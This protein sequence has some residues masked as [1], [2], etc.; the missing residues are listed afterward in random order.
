MIENFKVGN[1]VIV[2]GKV[3]YVGGNYIQVKVGDDK[4][5]VLKTSASIVK[6]I[7][8][9]FDFTYNEKKFNYDIRATHMISAIVGNQLDDYGQP[10]GHT[11]LYSMLSENLIPKNSIEDELEMEE[12][13]GKESIQ[14]IN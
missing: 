14:D 5:L 8:G 10:V 7:K 11:R 3:V 9:K 4:L 1:D 6:P 13:N 12:D 2:V